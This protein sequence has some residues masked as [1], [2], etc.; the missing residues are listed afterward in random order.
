LLLFI[1]RNHLPFRIADATELRFLLSGVYSSLPN[2]R[3][4]RTVLD[5]AA[6]VAVENLESI[7]CKKRRL[8]LSCLMHGR[9][10]VCVSRI[11]ALSTRGWTT[12]CVC[13]TACWMPCR[14]VR[15]VTRRQRSRC[16]LRSELTDTRAAT[17]RFLNGGATDAAKNV[18]SAAVDIVNLYEKQ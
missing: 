7:V 17:S 9:R 13:A 11:S 18:V 6:M 5:V 8:F 16:T 2:R 15:R 12:T 14:W 4:V 10:V 1:V 3:H